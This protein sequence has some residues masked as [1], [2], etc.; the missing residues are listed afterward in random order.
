VSDHPYD[1]DDQAV[2]VARHASR[3]GLCDTAIT[4]G[5]EITTVEGEWCHADCAEGEG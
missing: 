5:E 3:C 2:V 4:P 1:T